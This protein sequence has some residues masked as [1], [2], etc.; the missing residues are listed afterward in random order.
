MKM[1][2][3][4]PS[5]LSHIVDDTIIVKDGIITSFRCVRVTSDK[6]YKTNQLMD[7]SYPIPIHELEAK[8][9]QF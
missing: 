6:H 1:S 7:D 4:F 2:K 8:A 9:D 3:S 5:H